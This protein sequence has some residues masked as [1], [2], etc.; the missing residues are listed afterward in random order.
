[1]LCKPLHE[2]TALCNSHDMC[3][4]SVA[5]HTASSYPMAQR[6]VAAWLKANICCT[7]MLHTIIH[8]MYA[9]QA[10][11]RLRAQQHALQLKVWRQWKLVSRRRAATA[12]IVAA[13]HAHLTR[14]SV[15]LT[16]HKCGQAPCYAPATTTAVKHFAA[17][18]SQTFHLQMLVYV[19]LFRS[20][21]KRSINSCHVP[22]LV[23]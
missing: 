6:C 17:R 23:C 3:M 18:S 9:L 11:Q 15:V 5:R 21:V 8:N 4:S 10:R 14:Y 1:V 22:L 16:R 7:V 2:L 13:Q 19:L 12:S 20:F